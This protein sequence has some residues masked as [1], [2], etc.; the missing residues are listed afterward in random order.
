M[1]QAMWAGKAFFG[2]EVLLV[3]L[4]RLDQATAGEPFQSVGRHREQGAAKG[5]SSST[6]SQASATLPGGLFQQLLRAGV[7]RSDRAM[8][9]G[10]EQNPFCQRIRSSQPL[11]SEQAN[12]PSRSARL[13]CPTAM[14]PSSFSQP[15]LSQLT[16]QRVL[17]VLRQPSAIAVLA[18]IA[19]HGLL[20]VILPLLPMNSEEPKKPRPVKVVALTP[21]ERSRLPSSFGSGSG[22]KS[23]NPLPLDLP[24]SFQIPPP[25]PLY[26]FPPAVPPD[27]YPVE[28]T[29]QV[30][31]LDRTQPPE[32]RPSDPTRPP[33]GNDGDGDSDLKKKLEA[34]GKRQAEERKKLEEEKKKLEEER[35]QQSYLFN[36]ANTTYDDKKYEDFANALL[37]LSKGKMEKDVAKPQFKTLPYPEEACRYIP[38][39][40]QEKKIVAT[41]AIIQ[42]D[43]KLAEDPKILTSSGYKPLDDLAFSYVI[44]KVKN[45]DS[46]EFKP[47][48]NGNYRGILVMVEFD[49]EPTCTAK[50]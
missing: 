27:P 2:R 23:T 50:P 28:Q 41:T 29:R 10:R 11:R 14:S 26:S 20:A 33:N 5:C 25:T 1:H 24:P 47:S 36:P 7:R 15:P 18:S 4:D 40:K 32:T 37:T 30:P 12:F 16:P 35:K 3:D 43:G 38:K 9:R 39:D 46:D 44:D 21:A 19:V 22:L 13:S 6:Q 34:E 45:P 48:K 49:P 31:D 17:K 42:S 8:M